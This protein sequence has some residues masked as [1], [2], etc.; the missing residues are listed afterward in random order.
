MNNRNE[1]FYQIALTLLPKVGPVVA[2]NLISYCGSAEA[3]FHKKSDA[4]MR[5]PDI[6]EER[7]MQITKHSVFELVEAELDYIQKHKIKPLFYLSEDYPRR[8]KHCHDAPILL[9]FKGKTNL[10]AERMVAIVGTRNATEYGLEIT[11]QLVN[12]LKPYGVTI[13]SGLAYGIDIQA[14][15][16]AIRHGIPT[17]GVLA[18]GLNRLYPNVHRASAEKMQLNG[19]LMTEFASRSTLVP[20]NFPSRNRIVAGLCDAVI[21]VEAAKKG[22]ALITADIAMSYN[23]DVFAVPGRVGDP[24]SEGCNN[25][26][27]SNRAGLIT[28]IENIAYNMGWELESTTGKAKKVAP[29]RS[30]FLD[31]NEEEKKIV[32]Q[33]ELSKTV[34]IDELFH[35]CELTSGRL[36]TALLGLEM[37]GVVK[38]QPGKMYGLV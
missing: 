37:K 6:G 27:L 31:L 28:G 35:R 25:L 22:G 10:Q 1:L 38:C 34:H 8:L 30:L 14:H 24:F 13:V 29:Q 26:I 19:G 33:L 36:S 5:V 3:I 17:I 23:R 18:H 15:R 11:A 12:D 4:L 20:E 32:D 21:V 16:E 9:Y 2:R 7:A